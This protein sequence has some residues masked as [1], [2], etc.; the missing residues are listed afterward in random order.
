MVR[1][2]R[3]D[4]TQ[5]DYL[6]AYS[7]ACQR[8]N[9]VTHQS[10]SSHAMDSG[11]ESIG[12]DDE[13]LR[14]EDLRNVGKMKS[15]SQLCSVL[16]TKGCLVLTFESDDRVW[17]YDKKAVNNSLTLNQSNRFQAG[18]KKRKIPLSLYDASKLDEALAI[19]P[20]KHDTL[21]CMGNA[22]SPLAFLT[23]HRDAA[24]VYF[25][26]AYMY[27]QKAIEEARSS[28]INSIKNH[29]KW[30]RRYIVVNVYLYSSEWVDFFTV[31]SFISFADDANGPDS[32]DALKGYHQRKL[33]D[34]SWCRITDAESGLYTQVTGNGNNKKF[35]SGLA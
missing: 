7:A 17:N 5:K 15:C 32:I 19:G 16:E 23:S 24:K 27:F 8:I 18:K 30:L 4:M 25:D 26:L 13:K 29:L 10:L 11:N 35:T 2:C 1:L 9:I 31:L 6:S 33:A 34:I 3:Q 20:K 22:Q 12:S 21:W 28:G 14:I